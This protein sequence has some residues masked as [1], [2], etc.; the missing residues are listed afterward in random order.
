[1]CALLHC[2]LGIAFEIGGNVFCPGEADHRAGLLFVEHELGDVQ[3][4]AVVN[5]AARIADGDHVGLCPIQKVRGDR[6]RVTKALDDYFGFLQRY[7]EVLARAFDR[8][9]HA[10]AGGFIA[11]ER[12]AKA[13][14]LT[15][16]DARDKIPARHAIRIHDPGHDLGI[17]VDVGRRDVLPG[18]DDGQNS[19]CVPPREMFDFVG[20]HLLGVAGDAAFAAAERNIHHGAFPGH[21]R[22][23]SL[24]LVERHPGMEANAPFGRAARGVVLDAVAFKATDFAVVHPHGHRD[25]ENTLRGAHH[26]A[27]V[28]VEIEDI[29]GHFEVL[30][31]QLVRVGRRGECF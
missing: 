2:V 3:P 1:M 29:G 16:D 10:A 9:E 24:N 7:F 13:H 15:G 6:T 30:H 11:A 31:G 18:A 5:S 14:G 21:P 28:V 26:S 23:E 4:L 17:G 25:R 12:A 20:R 22:G 19:A 8:V 27:D